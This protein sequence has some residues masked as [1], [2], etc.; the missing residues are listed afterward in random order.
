MK[1]DA[2][3]GFSNQLLSKLIFVSK[4]NAVANNFIKEKHDEMKEKC[5]KLSTQVDEQTERIDDLEA[6]LTVKNTKIEDL[7]DELDEKNDEVANFK[8]QVE[9]FR[10]RCCLFEIQLAILKDKNGVLKKESD[11]Q[12]MV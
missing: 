3:T 11:R 9:T 5:E 6:Q 10:S 7:T 8:E 4:S 1:I 12:D 2:P